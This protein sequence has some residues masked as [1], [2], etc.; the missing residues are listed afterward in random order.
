MAA[1]KDFPDIA[2]KA[3][4]AD[5]SDYEADFRDALLGMKNEEEEET[6]EVEEEGSPEDQPEAEDSAEQPEQPEGQPEQEAPE[7]EA[8]PSLVDQLQSQLAEIQLKYQ[9]SQSQQGQLVALLQQLQ[10]KE[11]PTPVSSE[12]PAYDPTWVQMVDD[13]GSLKP[14]YKDRVD[15]NI[16]RYLAEYDRRWRDTQASLLKGELPQTVLEKVAQ[17]AEERAFDRMNKALEERLAKQQEDRVYSIAEKIAYREDGNPRPEGKAYVEALKE[18]ADIPDP[19]R[20]HS[21]ACRFAG[22]NADTGEPLNKPKPKEEAPAQVRNVE[23]AQQAMKSQ[24]KPEGPKSD[25]E[26]RNDAAAAQMLDGLKGQAYSG[27]GVLRPEKYP[28]EFNV[29]DESEEFGNALF[30]DVIA[31]MSK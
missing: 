3:P 23:D 28:T 21:L 10:G 30:N 20:K 5:D 17:Q 8:E 6:Q 7:E 11:E 19:W 27:N 25:I 13:N 16:P 18:L 29:T 1:S 14:E 15:P 4:R 31:D 22:F 2:Q 26:Q 12:M 9:E 24:E